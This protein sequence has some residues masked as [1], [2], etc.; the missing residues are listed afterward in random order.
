MTVPGETPQ[1]CGMREHYRLKRE[2]QAAANLFNHGDG[3]EAEFTDKE[4]D[5]F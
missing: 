5:E 1:Q 3:G 2:A 4:L